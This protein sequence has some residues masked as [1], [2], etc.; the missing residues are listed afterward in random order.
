[1]LI[2]AILALT[3]YHW[4]NDALLHSRWALVAVIVD[5]ADEFFLEIHVIEGVDS[6]SIV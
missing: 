4:C 3:L 2:A 6:F 5:T 1:M